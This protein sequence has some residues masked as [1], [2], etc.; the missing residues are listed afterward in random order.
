MPEKI[1][2]GVSG[3]AD[4]CWQHFVINSG[5][6]NHS[7][8]HR[9]FVADRLK[10]SVDRVRGLC[11]EGAP[12][13]GVT[14]ILLRFLMNEFGYRVIELEELKNKEP[15]LYKLAELFYTDTITYEQAYGLFEE[16]D[17]T[18]LLSRLNGKRGLLRHQRERLKSFIK[19]QQE[20][21]TRSEETPLEPKDIKPVGK[22]TVID[23]G[24]VLVKA[25]M[26]VV[27]YLLSPACNAHDRT[28][29]RNLVGNREYFQFTTLANR[30]CSERAKEMGEKE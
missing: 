19:Q 3:S 30:L 15:L 22:K 25:L 29:F 13:K 16:N 2:H 9:H 12:N 7:H 14:L 18:G 4:D 8:S 10:V 28:M 17:G 27:E 21:P 1:G 6:T 24:A 23:T 26:P 20:K 11:H 5:V